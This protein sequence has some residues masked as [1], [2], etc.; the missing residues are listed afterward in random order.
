[1]WNAVDSNNLHDFEKIIWN[2]IPA[3][4][5]EVVINFQGNRHSTSN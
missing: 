2:I 5:K 4:I 3:G 1:M